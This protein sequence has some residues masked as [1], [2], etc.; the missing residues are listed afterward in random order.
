MPP[1][2]PDMGLYRRPRD[3]EMVPEASGRASAGRRR[4]RSAWRVTSSAAADVSPER[5]MVW[6][7]L[8]LCSGTWLSR[9]RPC[10][11]GWTKST[12]AF[13]PSTSVSRAIDPTGGP[14]ALWRP[15]GTWLSLPTGPS[16]PTSPPPADTLEAVVSMVFARAAAIRVDLRELF[17]QRLH[18]LAPAGGQWPDQP[19][20][21]SAYRG[22]RAKAGRVGRSAGAP[23]VLLTAADLEPALRSMSPRGSAEVLA[24]TGLSEG[25]ATAATVASLMGVFDVPKLDLRV[26]PVEAAGGGSVDWA[27]VLPLLRRDGVLE[28]T[29]EPSQVDARWLAHRRVAVLGG[30]LVQGRD[31]TSGLRA[32]I[33]SQLAACGPLPLAE[34]LVG[35]RRPGPALGHIT[36]D[37]LTAWLTCQPDLQLRNGTARLVRPW[38]LPNAERAVLACIDPHRAIVPRQEL[39]QRLHEAGMTLGSAK[40]T[41]AVSTIL[42]P[43]GRGRYR[44]AGTP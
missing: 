22:V 39:I 43:V 29:A 20:G 30:L 12:C 13:K 35:L 25:R 1:S 17:E 37:Q 28:L 11:R 8:S 2:L 42:R 4:K 14:A 3:M 27:E 18:L 40:H 41:I 34:L 33:R 10:W 15:A 44:L 31:K 36:R 32:P 24:V 26:P 7:C 23:S 16:L 6:K 9:C 19:P 38:T 21:E 5:L